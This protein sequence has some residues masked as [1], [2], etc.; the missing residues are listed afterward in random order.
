MKT[1]T[2]NLDLVYSLPEYPQPLSTFVDG[3]IAVVNRH[4]RSLSVYA[5]NAG[6]GVF[7]SVEWRGA[8]TW[9]DV[10]YWLTNARLIGLHPLA[11][12]GEMRKLMRS[13]SSARVLHAVNVYARGA[14]AALAASDSGRTHF[15]A[16]FASENA[17]AARAAA[18]LL[19]TTY[20]VTVH[21][22]DIFRENPFLPY[23]MDGAAL[24][25]AISEFD[26]EW[27]VRLFPSLKQRVRVIHVGVP[28]ASLTEAARARCGAS[29]SGP[30]QIVS[31]GRLV[32]KKGMT[33]LVAAI[34]RLSAEGIASELTIV[35]EGPEREK[36]E[37]TIRHHGLGDRVNLVGARTPRDTRA[38]IRDADLFVLASERDAE[39]DMDGIPVVLMEA[40]ALGVPV[41]S[42]AISGIPEL[43]EH[44]RTGLLAKPNSADELA[45]Q[46]RSALA[47][48]VDVKAMVSAARERV[49]LN[50]DQ[51][52]NA[53]LLLDAIKA[54]RN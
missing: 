48:Q 28:V 42:T 23:V 27:L 19:D 4:V 5:L 46:I 16:H 11:Y 25:V 32:P 30:A 49:A 2:I 44:G 7:E 37:A 15:H 1:S 3:E 21:A 33:T 43:V 52:S 9:R 38:T 50:F 40:M 35:G 6:R 51:E 26:R 10:G 54:A 53:L 47:R 20:S 45:A 39:G 8:Q 31:A 29:P 24:V 14:P 22:Y 13:V 18:H 12:F 17:V 34:A 41:I 36:I